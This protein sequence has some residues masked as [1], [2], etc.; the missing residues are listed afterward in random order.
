[1]H[2]PKPKNPIRKREDG[3]TEFGGLTAPEYGKACGALC[4]V[5]ALVASFTAVLFVVAQAVRAGSGPLVR[6]GTAIWGA[7]HECSFWADNQKGCLARCCESAYGLPPCLSG[8]KWEVGNGRC[9]ILFRVTPVSGACGVCFLF[10]LFVL[11]FDIN[12]FAAFYATIS[13]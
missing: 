6:P 1:M 3:S 10:L 8:R 13:W 2:F 7:E 12:F 9:W 5:W 4:A 11:Y